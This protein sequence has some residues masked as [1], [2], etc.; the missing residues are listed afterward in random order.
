M[1]FSASFDTC[2]ASMGVLLVEIYSTLRFFL[3]FSDGGATYQFFILLKMKTI[4]TF[5]CFSVETMQFYTFHFQ[6]D[7]SFKVGTL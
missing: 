3:K 6:F 4:N 5:V 2:G 7:D 1:N